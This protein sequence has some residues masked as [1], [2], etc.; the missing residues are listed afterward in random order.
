MKKA[1]NEK[2]KVSS[3]YTRLS[4]NCTARQQ[5]I[6]KKNSEKCSSSVGTSCPLMESPIAELLV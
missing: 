5:G 3:Y 2:K 1:I 6:S 4:S